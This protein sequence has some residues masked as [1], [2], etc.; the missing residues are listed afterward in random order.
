MDWRNRVG[1]RRRNVGVGRRCIGAN[2]RYVRVGMDVT[3]Y[4]N[5]KTMVWAS[6][7]LSISSIPFNKCHIFLHLNVQYYFLAIH[8]LR[9]QLI[10]VMQCMKIIAVG[11]DIAMGRS[12]QQDG[13]LQWGGTQQLQW[14]NHCNG[15]IVAMG[16]SLQQGDHCSRTGH[17]KGMG[18]C[19]GT[20][21][22]THV[23]TIHRSV[24]T[25]I[26]ML[27]SPW[28]VHQHNGWVNI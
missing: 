25:N 10:Y 24:A 12:L 22:A 14:D 27:M 11:R 1:V 26:A 28:T 21:S 8:D 16:R 17:C 18:H 19:S 6:C 23:A 9:Y 2:R 5:I 13:T 7:L 20:N 15:A 3:F 4:R